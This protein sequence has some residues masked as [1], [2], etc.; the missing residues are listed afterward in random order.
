MELLFLR[1]HFNVLQRWVMR[2]NPIAADRFRSTR[3]VAVP[4][5]HSFRFHDG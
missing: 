2:P 5:H 1:H 4:G 3:I